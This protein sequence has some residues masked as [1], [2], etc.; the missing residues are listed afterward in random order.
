MRPDWIQWAGNHP[1][2]F[3]LIVGTKRLRTKAGLLLVGF[4]LG[5]GVYN[6]EVPFDLDR[7]NA[8]VFVGLAMVLA[9]VAFRF[10]ALGSLRKKEELA[11][12]GVYSLCRHPLYLGS[13]LM[14]Y[15]FCC[16]LNDSKLFLIASAYFILF[17]GLTIAWEEI[18]LA[19]RYGDAYHRYAN[20][21]PLILPV[22]RPCRGQFGLATA[23]RN[24][25]AAL[26]AV[27]T[28]LLAAIESMAEF[29]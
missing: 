3:A 8:W 27:T 5:E 29:I 2:W 13:V 15:G 22:G 1:R 28:I 21:T 25:G 11:T 4:G 14:A 24:G 6:H 23:L 19:Q 20:E 16:L 26:I 17:Y 12:T 7:P 10:A 9:G 18:R